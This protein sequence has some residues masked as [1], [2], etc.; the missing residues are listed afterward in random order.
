[1]KTGASPKTLNII[2]CGKV[3]KTLARLW[4]QRSTLIVQDI[5]N[6]TP[7]S[8]RKAAAFIG[9]GHAVDDYAGLRA[10]DVC[11]IAATDDQIAA[12]CEQLAHAGQLGPST[13]VFHCSGALP[14]SVLQAAVQCGASVASIHPIRSF[15]D[16]AQAA[17]A[18]D[19]TYCGAEGDTQ[20]LEA[21]NDAFSAIGARIV[22]IHSDGKILYHS[23][24]VFACNYLVT[25]LDVAL[26]AYQQSGVPQEVALRLMEPLVRGTIDNVFKAGTVNALTGPIA[27]GDLATTAKQA[28]AVADWCAD[29]GKLYEQFV[30]LTKELAARR[31]D[32]DT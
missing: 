3:G 15:A 1:M 30:A 10:A 4:A 32:A 13:I 8:A 29:Y 28:H 9:A 31:N 6:R 24:A 22:P 5:L 11:L 23:A 25:L 21:L 19:G 16:P 7:D 14:S 17:A 2:G 26:Q 18:F 12:C 20:A 27:R